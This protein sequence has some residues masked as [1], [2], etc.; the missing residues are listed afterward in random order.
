MTLLAADEAGY[1]NLVK[2]VSIGYTEG[3]YHRPRIDKDVLAKHSQGLIGLSGCLSGEIA[4]HLRNGQEAAAL[5]S[6]GVFSEIFGRGPLLPRGD[7]PRHRG[8]APGEPGAVSASTTA[9]GLPLVATNDAHYLQPGRPPGPR[10]AGLHRLRQEGP[11]HRPAALRHQR[12]LR[13]ERGRDGGGVPRPP[14][15]ARQHRPHRGDV[16]VQPASRRARCPPSTCRPASP[17]RATSRR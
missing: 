4:T 5:Q 3:F 6:V 13:E 8:P 12:V 1:H 11:R 7:G 14:G 17:S 16:R 9:P 15:R 2:L 10:R